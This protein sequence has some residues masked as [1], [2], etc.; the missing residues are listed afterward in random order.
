MGACKPIRRT[1]RDIAALPPDRLPSSVR[2]HL[3]SC[4]DCARALAAAR[5]AR[6]FVSVVTAT[7]E[8]PDEFARRVLAALPPHPARRPAE[9]AVWRPAW[10]LVPVFAATAAAL[11]ILFQVSAPP[12]AAELIPTA[13]LSLGERLVLEERPPDPDLVLAAVM[14]EAE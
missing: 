8:P 7:P 9:P 6:G 11:L 10:G 13:N 12:V 14:E 1:L 3:T 5:L 2:D 4:A